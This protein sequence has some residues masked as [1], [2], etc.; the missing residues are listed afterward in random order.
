MVVAVLGLT[1]NQGALSQAPAC[2]SFN[3]S[4]TVQISTVGN[5]ATVV[6]DTA[7]AVSGGTVSWTSK[8]GETW[9]TDFADDAHSPF[10]AG[11]RHHQGNV[12]TTQGDRVRACSQ[13]S[14]RFSAAAGGCVFKYAATHV[15][16][17]K[18]STIDPQVVLKP[19]T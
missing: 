10:A 9:S 19:G 12:G 14:A 11:R 18:T 17:G 7:C 16:G 8:D 15:K 13:S 3:Q 1:A 6:P 5:A 2:T 4:V